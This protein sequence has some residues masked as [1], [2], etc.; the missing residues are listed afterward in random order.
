MKLIWL[1]CNETIATEVEEVLDVAGVEFYSVW[2]SVLG[3]DNVG[4]N[5]R[6]DD[7]VFP[8]KNW[9][10]Q[11]LCTEEIVEEVRRRLDKLAEDAY[12]RDSGIAMYSVEAERAY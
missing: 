12:V 11:F 10:F 7:V 1:H 3:R 2:R 9:A 5:T 4:G 8:G 6:R